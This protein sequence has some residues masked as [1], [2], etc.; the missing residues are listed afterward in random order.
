[1]PKV[2]R[3]DTSESLRL[4]CDDPSD[5][6][7]VRYA[8][9]GEPFREGI[10]IGIENREFDKDVTVMLLDKDAIKLRDMLLKHYPI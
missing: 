5:S 9:R 7:V 8:N 3:R 4:P 6:F 2:L 10:L 1:M